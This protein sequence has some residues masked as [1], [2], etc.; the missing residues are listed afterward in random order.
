MFVHLT[1]QM[2]LLARVHSFIKRTTVHE[3]PVR[4]FTNCSLNVQFFHTPNF[5]I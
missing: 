3:L 1:N 5:H 4:Q 2:E